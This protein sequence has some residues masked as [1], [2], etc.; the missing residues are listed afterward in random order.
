MYPC[1]GG[2]YQVGVL[3]GTTIHGMRVK[4]ESRIWEVADE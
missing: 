2:P 4:R 3:T 1:S